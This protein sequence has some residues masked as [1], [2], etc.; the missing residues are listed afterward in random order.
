MTAVDG[1]VLLVGVGAAV[2]LVVEAG[3]VV[4]AAVVVLA[5][6]VVVVVPVVVVVVPAVVVVVAAVEVVGAT[7]VEVVDVVVGVCDGSKLVEPPELVSTLAAA[8][9]TP[10]TIRSVATAMAARRRADVPMREGPFCAR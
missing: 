6:T 5:R 1:S 9:V 2:E 10:P 4:G 3:V 7:V 8:A